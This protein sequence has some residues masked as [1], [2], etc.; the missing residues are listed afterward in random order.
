[1]PGKN[2]RQSSYRVEWAPPALQSYRDTLQ[3]IA[4]QDTET[5][6]LFEQR[7]MRALSLLAEQ[8]GI[9]TPSTRQG[10]RTFA[11]PKTGHTVEYQAQDGTVVILRWYRQRRKRP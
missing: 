10:K 2:S 11:V 6:A 4:E 7:V 9:G 3:H 1:M 5:L 8:P